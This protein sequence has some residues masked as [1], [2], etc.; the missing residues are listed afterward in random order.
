[1]SVLMELVIAVQTELTLF[2]IA[3]G[4][5]FVV[6]RGYK[7]HR[8]KHAG[9]KCVP[10]PD[11]DSTSTSQQFSLQQPSQ[12]GNSGSIQ[13]FSSA[14]L[15][16]LLQ[17]SQRAFQQADY[18]TVVR[19]WASL[20]KH[21]TVP[22]AHFV[23]VVESMQRLKRE[24]SGSTLREVT[25]FLHHRSSKLNMEQ[26]NDLLEPL[27]KSLD[28][29]LVMGL[30]GQ[31][32]ALNIS[33][34]ERSY[35]I[36]MTMHFATRNF[37][38]VQSLSCEMDS[39]GHTPSI[40]ARLVLLK[41]ALRTGNLQE[42]IVQHK[43]V[44]SSP[45]GRG[46]TP[47]HLS[48]QLVE[49]GC[50]EH[51]ASSVLTVLEQSDVQL[52]TDALNALL[53]ESVRPDGP[54][55]SA[56]VAALASR[57]SA[58]LNGRSFQ[59]L[60]KAAGQDREQIAKLLDELGQSR[61]EWGSDVATAVLAACGPEDDD[62]LAD[63]L[64][65]MISAK[66]S[67]QIPVLA[68]LIRFFA[69]TGKPEKACN[70]YDSNLHFLNTARAAQFDQRRSLLDS[71]T[72]KILAAAACACGRNDLAQGLF[73]AGPLDTGKHIAMIS[74]CAR[75]GNLD[76]AFSVFE[77]VAGA[78]GE[79]TPSL[80]NSVLDACVECRSL[81]RAETWM[82]RMKKEGV[83]DVVSYNT[84]IK[85]QLKAERLDKARNLMCEMKEAGCRPNH[86]TYNELVIAL[87]RSERP[88]CH[89]QVWDVVSE[90]QA[91]SVKPNCVTCSI[92][93][94]NLKTN[95]SQKDV[96][97]S[98][99]LVDAMDEP[100]DEVL[101]SSVVEACV[102][103]GQPDL[104]LKKLDNLQATG[105]MVSVCGAH[106]F[107]SLIKAYGH[108]KNIAGVWR[109]WK[110]MRSRH[111][112]PTSITIGCMVEAVVSNGDVDGGYELIQDLSK[113][114][115][116][117][118]QLNAVIYCS[119]LKG[120]ARSRRM[121]RVWAV[122]NEMLSRNIEPSIVTFNAMIDACARNAQMDAVPE[123]QTKMKAKGLV[124]N[125]ITYST[126][127]KGFC[128]RGDVKSALSVLDEMRRTTKMKPDE[129]VY[130][131]LLDGCAQG[132]LV[133]EGERLLD[134]MQ[135]EGIVPSSYTL[136]AL[137][138]LMGQAKRPDQAFSLVEEISRKYRFK[139]NSHVYG[140]LIQACV[141]VRDH[142]RAMQVF[143]LMAQERMQLDSRA[144]QALVRSSMTARNH[145]QSAYVCRVVM[146]LPGSDGSCSVV[147]IG[148][149]EDDAFIKETLRTIIQAGGEA[150]A[151]ASPLL[152]HV[153]EKGP[154]RA[155][156]QVTRRALARNGN[157]SR[158]HGQ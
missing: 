36:L 79:L 106:T 92:L 2:A 3:F 67:G 52:T 102:R 38:E 107:G 97:R 41:T 146:G 108:A 69:D 10:I 148:R 101:L 1:M 158:W 8:P 45:S 95:A 112:K 105:K 58:S 14:T 145:K 55:I 13:D 140:A 17:R 127:I 53:A 9:K 142:A 155:V 24:D 141:A 32:P 115:Q 121:E 15:D 42:A 7:A 43:A 4:L 157:A 152:R 83:A 110:E 149:A 88:W 22:L 131:N 35:D 46:T 64:S 119:V 34:D 123:L 151:L 19:V 28:S 128:Q 93:L 12:P 30:I 99:D 76:G 156:E 132:G 26:I 82:H 39:K 47:S 54:E 61:V 75:K 109:Y 37:K 27:A 139:P 72:E 71:R 56:R 80:Y 126:T 50:R 117:Q 81:E 84:L 62:M 77:A 153:S 96:L 133:A 51:D 18:R 143:D 89:A 70:V 29:E 5:H 49:L 116:C 120:Y 21:D 94:K 65:G 91:E 16:Q 130:N 111:V 86:V 100:M 59:M 122:W 136:T 33:M 137:V 31:L 103:V 85:S 74:T 57:C 6:F 90:M 25:E 20:K 73:A 135:R 44:T 11:N 124:P 40:C 63:K 154:R 114:A 138:K 68:S 78:D 150:A 87:L 60:I 144:W 118:D 147:S 98:M 48:A 134:D 129:I 113:D 125:Q 23:C 66:Q 104:L